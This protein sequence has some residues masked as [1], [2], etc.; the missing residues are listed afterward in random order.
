MEGDERLVARISNFSLV[1]ESVADTSQEGQQ[2][3]NE[4]VRQTGNTAKTNNTDS[5]IAR[6]TVKGVP[7]NT[8]GF[9]PNIVDPLSAT[10]N[11]I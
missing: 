9:D 10:Q 4:N 7:I 11:R 2:N 3:N 5:L 6:F 8:K 1:P